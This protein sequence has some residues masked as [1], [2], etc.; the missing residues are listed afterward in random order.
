M[1]GPALAALHAY[2]TCVCVCPAAFCAFHVRPAMKLMS[3]ATERVTPGPA[4]AILLPRRYNT[5]AMYIFLDQFVSL[6]KHVV[7]R[8]VR[9][10]SAH[11]RLVCA[12]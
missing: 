7:P 1:A 8:S 2:A 5:S 3:V 4:R 10:H 12:R 6:V 11:S 9:A